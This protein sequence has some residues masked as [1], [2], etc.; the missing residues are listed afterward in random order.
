MG[1][2]QRG[3]ARFRPDA[4]QLFEHDGLVLLVERREGLVHAQDFR[5]VGKGPRDRN[6]LLH[7]AR[8]LIRIGPGVIR[9]PHLLEEVID[10]GLDLRS[11]KAA[12]LQAVA[13]VAL[14]RE[15]GE[16]RVLLENHRRQR[17]RLVAV[18][19]GDV[20]VRFLIKAIDDAKQGGLAAAARPDD[21]HEFTRG[22]RQADVL[23]GRDLLPVD[24][25]HLGKAIQPHLHGRGLRLS[26]FACRRHLCN[27]HLSAL[28]HTLQAVDGTTGQLLLRFQPV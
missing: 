20:A 22:D 17:L 25:K 28:I 3:L 23:Q 14:H 18:E 15:P 2:E 1:D 9:Q 26:P 24:T 5:I 11:R 4:G 6:A 13:D 21:H 7:P 12:H 27:R 10:S 16:H 8:E 19:P